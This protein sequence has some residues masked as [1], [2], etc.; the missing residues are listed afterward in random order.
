M[1]KLSKLIKEI[2]L[3]SEEDDPEIRIVDDGGFL[4]IDEV[5]HRDDYADENLFTGKAWEKG[6]FICL[7]IRR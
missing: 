5:L 6:D 7:E 3:I 2:R 4:D 1:M